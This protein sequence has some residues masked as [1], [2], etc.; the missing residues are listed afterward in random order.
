MASLLLLTASTLLCKLWPC[1]SHRHIWSN[2]KRLD[3]SIQDHKQRLENRPISYPGDWMKADHRPEKPL[4]IPTFS[5]AS[6]EP[7]ACKIR[8]GEHRSNENSEHGT[9]GHKRHCLDQAASGGYCFKPVGNSGEPQEQQVQQPVEPTQGEHMAM[10]VG[11]RQA[12]QEEHGV[13]ANVTDNMQMQRG[14]HAQSSQLQNGW[15]ATIPESKWLCIS[16][17]DGKIWALYI[18]TKKRR[19][20][21]HRSSYGQKRKGDAPS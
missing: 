8:D 17:I 11:I 9:D 10:Q 5:Y 12:V 21:G 2:C 19:Y 16:D 7:E 6:S 15:H 20:Q 4:V 18:I 13:H 14:I 3:P 1:R